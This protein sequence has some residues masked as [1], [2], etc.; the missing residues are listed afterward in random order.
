MKI[1]FFISSAFLFFSGSAWAMEQSSLQEKKVVR[2]SLLDA[3]RA[4]NGLDFTK[5]HPRTRHQYWQAAQQAVEDKTARVTRL[6]IDS[7]FWP[8]KKQWWGICQSVGGL[9]VAGLAG[10]LYCYASTLQTEQEHTK[11]GLWAAAGGLGLLGLYGALR[12]SGQ[13]WNHRTAAKIKRS[14]KK[15]RQFCIIEQEVKKQVPQEYLQEGTVPSDQTQAKPLPE[16]VTGQ[17]DIVQA[18]L[19]RMLYKIPL[20]EPIPFPFQELLVFATQNNPHTTCIVTYGAPDHCREMVQLAATARKKEGQA[21]KSFLYMPDD[22]LQASQNMQRSVAKKIFNQYPILWEL[23]KLYTGVCSPEEPP[24][25]DASPIGWFALPPELHLHILGYVVGRTLYAAP[26]YKDLNLLK[27]FPIPLSQQ[28]LVLGIFLWRNHFSHTQYEV[29]RGRK[30]HQEYYEVSGQQ[31]RFDD[32]LAGYAYKLEA[33]AYYWNLFCQKTTM[34]LW[35]T[36]KRDC[37][38]HACPLRVT[39]IQPDLDRIDQGYYSYCEVDHFFGNERE[40]CGMAGVLEDKRYPKFILYVLSRIMYYQLGIPP[41]LI[42][43]YLGEEEIQHLRRSSAVHSEVE[44]FKPCNI[45][46][47]VQE[48]YI[49]EFLRM[50]KEEREEKGNLPY[51]TKGQ[52]RK[53]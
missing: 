36:T 29:L 8:H 40:R 51:Y 13:V 46:Q 18:P 15:V 45:P 14:Q 53:K 35:D 42:N 50:F 1:I 19:A 34:P 17:E 7:S 10:K 26:D 39:E 33:M 48:V 38:T 32:D 16:W 31:K 28:E 41:E 5:H 4:R 25:G 47:R 11:Y 43:F 44:V 27:Y 6:T 2:R 12:G 24:E 52:K 22:I 37:V 9:G 23:K 21:L 30:Q 20:R 3:S 49:P